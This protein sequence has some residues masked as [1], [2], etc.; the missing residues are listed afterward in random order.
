VF[1]IATCN[2]YSKLPPE[3]TRMGRWDAIFFVDNPSPKE[4]LLILGIYS[5]AFGVK[6]SPK[7]IPAPEDLEGYSGA[8]IRQVAIEAAYNGGDKANVCGR[9]CMRECGGGTAW[10]CNA[11]PRY[12]E[13]RKYVPNVVAT[14]K[15]LRK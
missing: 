15:S 5:E 10:Q 13:T 9:D 3:Y 6:T 12:A 4:R 1:V 14:Y 7:S 8:E 11:F 2:D